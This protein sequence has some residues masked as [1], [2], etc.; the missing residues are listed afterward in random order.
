MTLS[1]ISELHQLEFNPV[2]AVERIILSNFEKCSHLHTTQFKRIELHERITWCNRRA[3][4]LEIREYL[5]IFVVIQDSRENGIILKFFSQLRG[6]KL[7]VPTYIR[8]SDLQS[9]P[10]THNSIVQ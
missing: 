7:Y 1:W 5:E 8:T 4:D 6:S 9:C 2:Q 10:P 3:Y